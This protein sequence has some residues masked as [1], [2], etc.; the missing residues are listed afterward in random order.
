MT[1]NLKVFSPCAHTE[2]M[3]GNGYVNQRDWYDYI[4]M[5]T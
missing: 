3:R 2:T 5:Y 1:V 4:T